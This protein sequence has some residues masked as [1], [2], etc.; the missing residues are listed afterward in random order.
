[1]Q[2][3]NAILHCGP[4]LVYLWERCGEK[5]HL[6]KVM[7]SFHCGIIPIRGDQWSWIVKSLLVRGHGIS[8]AT[9]LLQ[10]NAGQFITLLN[11]RSDVKETHEIRKH[12]YPTNKDNS[13]IPLFR[14]SNN[15]RL[16]FLNTFNDIKCNWT[17]CKILSIPEMHDITCT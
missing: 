14:S 4:Y 9:G 15:K 16:C 10:Y 2:L 17:Q 7:D 11:V 6:L 3:S 8:W 12:W 5:L 1:M 13:I